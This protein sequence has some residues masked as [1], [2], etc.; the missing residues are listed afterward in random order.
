MPFRDLYAAVSASVTS[1]GRSTRWIIRQ[2]VWA[3]ITLFYMVA[4]ASA[5]KWS[6]ALPL[7][8]LTISSTTPVFKEGGMNAAGSWSGGDVRSRPMSLAVYSVDST[9]AR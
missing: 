6:D 5:L 8:A 1:S 4:A 7:N 3:A 9:Y 2:A